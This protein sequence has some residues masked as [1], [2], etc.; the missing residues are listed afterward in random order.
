MYEK[1]IKWCKA[2]CF[3]CPDITGCK[4]LKGHF[5]RLMF[6]GKKVLKSIIELYEV[7]FTQ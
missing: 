5:F 7:A 6:K 2:K 1:R 4:V 3:D